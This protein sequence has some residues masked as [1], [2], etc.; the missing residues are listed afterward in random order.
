MSRSVVEKRSIGRESTSKTLLS[1]LMVYGEMTG[2]E[3]K[4]VHEH[5]REAECHFV[6][7]E[8]WLWT[9]ADRS[10]ANINISSINDAMVANWEASGDQQPDPSCSAALCRSSLLMVTRRGT[11][12][13]GTF[14]KVRQSVVSSVAWFWIT[15]EAW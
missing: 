2:L 7:H 11:R 6:Y 12:N 4:R 1:L 9:N 5:E 8:R 10:K 15:F 3:D 13:S 14:W